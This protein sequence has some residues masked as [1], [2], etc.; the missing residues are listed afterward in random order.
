M[1]AQ[2]TS[3]TP[4]SLRLLDGKGDLFAGTDPSSTTLQPPH[5]I[6][7]S[8]CADA[9]VKYS[10]VVPPGT[11]VVVNDRDD[12]DSGP[13]YERDQNMLRRAISAKRH[14]SRET[15]AALDR[16]SAS[17][18]Q[19]SPDES[20][21]D[22]VPPDEPKPKN[23]NNDVKQP[24]ATV[25]SW[26]YK[27]WGTFMEEKV[28]PRTTF[29]D[30]RNSIAKDILRHPTVIRLLVGDGE[31]A[32]G[33]ITTHPH[34]HLPPYHTHPPTH[35]RVEVNYSDVVPPDTSIVVQ[36]GRTAKRRTSSL[37]TK[38]STVRTDDLPK[39][40]NDSTNA[41]SSDDEEPKEPVPKR[42]RVDRGKL[43]VAKMIAVAKLEVAKTA[44][45]AAFDAVINAIAPSSEK[46][47]NGRDLADVKCDVLSVRAAFAP[48]TKNPPVPKRP[49]KGFFRFVQETRQPFT[50]RKDLADRWNDLSADEQR[51][52]FD[53]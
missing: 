43:E 44:A 23:D 6:T 45:L 7:H 20:E 37:D 36:L 34:P 16:Y 12:S 25:V 47:E 50:S 52:Y 29:G 15:S 31:L 9:E 18:A 2:A 10:D 35:V 53:P 33:T 13:K 48:Q 11:H 3:R 1:I 49:L 21:S 8:L 30:M 39:E 42:R 51:A 27:P 26:H 41:V 24:N 22:I 17:A 40:D 38:H 5:P 14:A 28:D 32:S 46:S 4:A 19:L